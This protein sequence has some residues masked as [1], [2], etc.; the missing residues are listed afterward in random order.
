MLQDDNVTI[1]SWAVKIEGGDDVT[2][3]ACNIVTRTFIFKRQTDVYKPKCFL[4]A[5]ISPNSLV[6]FSFKKK[7]TIFFH[8]ENYDKSHKLWRRFLR[9]YGRNWNQLIKRVR[10]SLYQYRIRTSK[11]TFSK[12]IKFIYHVYTDS[13]DFFHYL[14]AFLMTCNLT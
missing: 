5:N 9:F 12:N 7:I 8:V 1:E 4:C 14:R 6:M 2:Y 10:Q 13:I 11:N 3:L